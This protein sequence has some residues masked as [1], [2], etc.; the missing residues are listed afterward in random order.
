MKI[1]M[2][3]TEIHLEAFGENLC[4][5]TDWI[6]QE[7]NAGAYYIFFP[8]MSFS[9]FS[10]RTAY[11]ASLA[12]QTHEQM[13]QLAQQYHIG[14][15]YGWT[16]QNAVQK[17][18]NHYA[19]CDAQGVQQFDYTKIHPFSYGDEQKYYAKGYTMSYTNLSGICASAVICYDLRFPELFRNAACHQVSLMLVPANWLHQ[20]S[21]HWRIL[22][23]ARAIENQMYVLG[24]NC[25]GH[26]GELQFDGQSCAI[27]PEGEILVQCDCHETLAFVEIVDDVKY[28]RETFPTMRDINMPLYTKLYEEIIGK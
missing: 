27:D 8:V 2:A 26:Q 16:A 10:M 3:Q 21:T 22:L 14:I 9:G 1:A 20:R 19:I 5:G 6:V 18:E 28:Y 15:G 13:H 4:R 7:E 24:I 11:A 12:E 25:C 23:Q 17:G